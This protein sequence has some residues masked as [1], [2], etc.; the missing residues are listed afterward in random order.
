MAN[1][2]EQGID[3]TE[4]QI[5]RQLKKIR[6]LV[7]DG[8]EIYKDGSYQGE[9][10]MDVLDILKKHMPTQDEIGDAMFLKMVKDA[11]IDVKKHILDSLTGIDKRLASLYSHDFCNQSYNSIYSMG[12]VYKPDEDNPMY[13]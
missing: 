4:N 9:I 2:D 11:T 6:E 13:G 7:F 5:E 12:L 10:K 3:L 1:F 8:Y